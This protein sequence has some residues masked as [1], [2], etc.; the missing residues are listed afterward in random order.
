[1]NTD[2]AFQTLAVAIVGGMGITFI[3]RKFSLP[4]IVI[5]FAGGILLGH[6][7]LGL[8]TPA[9]IESILPAIVSLAISVILFEGGLTL[10]PRDYLRSSSA[11]KRLLTIGA[12]ITWIGSALVVKWCFGVSWEVSLLAG[13]LVI[14]TGP[15]VIMPLLRRLRLD[16]EVSSILHWE[17]VM[18]DA[19][20]VF[21]AVFCYELVV[22]NEPGL[23][24]LGFAGRV[25]VGAIVGVLGGYALQKAL[26]KDWVPDALT[27]P[28]V[29]A[30]AVF[31]FAIAETCMHEAGLL[32]VT[33]AG[34]IVG[35]RRSDNVR[36]ILTF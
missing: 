19:V 35:R 16:S 8:L 34:I 27:N 26:E 7:A 5:L 9:S 12:L 20:G 30:A 17:G 23:A 3:A 18:I 15:T 25:L 11:I 14:V 22:V 4:T 33:I 31:F 32:A 24:V 2:P 13:S 29:L 10:D 21:I 36:Q 28:F 1:M 6:E